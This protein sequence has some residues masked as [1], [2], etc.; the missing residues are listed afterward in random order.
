MTKSKVPQLIM[1]AAWLLTGSQAMAGAATASLVVA[2]DR[3]F[4]GNEETRE[5]F[6]R[7]AEPN[8]QLVFITDEDSRKYLDAAVAALRA[9]GAQA[10]TVLPMFVSGHNPNW[11]LA[12]SWLAGDI[13]G[14]AIDCTT[15]RSFGDT[16]LAVDVLD[17]ALMRVEEP[18]GKRLICSMI[19]SRDWAVIGREHCGQ[20]PKPVRAYS[21]RR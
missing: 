15:S 18:A 9:E 2:P 4:M 17:E 5:A 19:C 11:S 12:E 1:L 13:C 10:V 7:I 8:K 14:L 21:T 20:C 16:Y 6:A 3:G